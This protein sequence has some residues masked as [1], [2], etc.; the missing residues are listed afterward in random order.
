MIQLPK[1]W[2]S[3]VLAVVVLHLSCTSCTLPVAPDDDAAAAVERCRASAWVPSNG[4]GD[5]DAFLGW[6]VGL[7]VCEKALALAPDNPVALAAYGRALLMTEQ[8]PQAVDAMRR[9][10]AT[11]HPYG[12][13]GMGVLS[14]VGVAVEVD[15]DDAQAVAWYRKAAEQ[16][17]ARA[18]NSLG[19]MY[20]NGRGVEQ[21][22]TQAVAW[23]RK[24]AEQGDAV[25]Q[26]NL[27]LM[28]ADGR[29]V[30]QD[31]NQALVWYRKAAEQGDADAWRDLWSL[32]VTGGSGAE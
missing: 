19:L 31:D 8:Y 11:G 23:Y 13:F 2:M 10:A 14:D 18:Q 6:D 7:R 4:L 30:E 9:A 16:G 12:Q 5:A 26:L 22:D 15:Q 3:G 17:Y 29:G 24:A 20:A 32:Y 1:S 27:G 28:Y 25:A 21:D